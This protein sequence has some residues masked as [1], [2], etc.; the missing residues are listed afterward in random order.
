MNQK[1]LLPLLMLLIA[2][3]ACSSIGNTLAAISERGSISFVLDKNKYYEE[4][5]TPPHINIALKSTFTTDKE[6]TIFVDGKEIYK[7]IAEAEKITPCPTVFPFAPGIF[8]LSASVERI[9]GNIVTT[10][11]MVEW[12]PPTTEL[13]KFAQLLAGGNGNDPSNGYIIGALVMIIV[14]TLAMTVITKGSLIGAF[15]GFFTSLLILAGIYLLAGSPSSALTVFIGTIVLAILGF[16]TAIAINFHNR[17]GVIAVGTQRRTRRL[18]AK[19]QPEEII[20]Q[21]PLFAGSGK[22]SPQ[23]GK[24]KGNSNR[25]ITATKQQ[26]LDLLDEMEDQ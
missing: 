17:G 1:I 24:P 26:L 12:S 3:F 4:V 25:Q 2:N 11:T 10:E 20:E 13:D 18:D 19:G 16:L 21:V 7:C 6:A 9:D 14:L 15:T 5:G 22:Y 8:H 23:L